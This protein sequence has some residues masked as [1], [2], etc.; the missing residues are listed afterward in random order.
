MLDISTNRKA[1]EC[2]VGN[3]LS[4]MGRVHGEAIGTRANEF[5]REVVSKTGKH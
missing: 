1:F 3:L 5:L 2:A 4:I